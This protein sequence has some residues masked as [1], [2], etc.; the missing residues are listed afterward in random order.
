MTPK[1]PSAPK[2]NAFKSYPVEFFLTFRLV[3]MTSPFGVTTF[4]LTIFSFDVPYFSVDKP[5]PP[6]L[7]IPPMLGFDDGSGPKIN[8]CG[9]KNAFNSFFNAPAPTVAVRCVRSSDIDFISPV[10]ITTPP[11]YATHP[12][13]NPVP[14]PLGTTGT[15]RRRHRLTIFCAS[16]VDVIWT[17]ASGVA[18]GCVVPMSRFARSK[19]ALFLLFLSKS[20]LSSVN[21]RAG[22]STARSRSSTK[23]NHF[24]L[25]ISLSH[26]IIIIIVSSKSSKHSF[27]ELFF[28]R[29]K[30]AA[31]KKKVSR[32]VRILLRAL[33]CSLSVCVC[34]RV[35]S[36]RARLSTLTQRKP[37]LLLKAQ[38]KTVCLGS[39]SQPFFLIIC[40]PKQSPL[41]FWKR[42]SLRFSS[43]LFF[44]YRAVVVVS[45]SPSSS[46]L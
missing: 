25:S 23:T 9:S 6:V 39:L 14:A 1:V 46:G 2:Y 26:I 3:S 13:S 43:L 24:F 32:V 29:K 28:S 8:P 33:Y 27:K 15:L 19:G 10:S 5:E 36:A 42:R 21:T 37:S 12:P 18:A 45:L 40:Y 44:V 41:F 22:S 30:R 16:V 7:A 4:M 20:F 11:E 35:V 17:T 31:L 34:V 38:K